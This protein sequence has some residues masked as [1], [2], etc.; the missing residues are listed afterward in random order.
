MEEAINVKFKN[1]QMIR[2]SMQMVTPSGDIHKHQQPN[3]HYSNSTLLLKDY[4][5]KMDHPKEQISG[6]IDEGVKTRSSLKD[7]M[8]S[9]ALIYEMVPKGN[10]EA[11]ADQSWIEAMQEELLI[12]NQ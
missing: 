1:N 12:H 2:E 4:K 10:D 11:V 3:A 8:N 9:L 5:F 6:K 7:L